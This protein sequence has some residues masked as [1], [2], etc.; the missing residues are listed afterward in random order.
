MQALVQR[1]DSLEHELLYLRLSY[2]INSLYADINLFANDLY[3]QSIAIELATYTGNFDTALA[4]AC[5]MIYEQYL[6]KKESTSKLIAAKQIFLVSKAS[7]E[8]LSE[9]ELSLLL[10]QGSALDTA[11]KAVE[12]ASNKLKTAIDGYISF[13][14]I[15]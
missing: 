1:V 2:E 12:A 11:F 15:H 3:T 14:N 4:Q 10:E 13:C 7:P 5:Q 6:L 8:I 9:K